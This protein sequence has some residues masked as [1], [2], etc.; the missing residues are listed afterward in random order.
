MFVAIMLFLVDASVTVGEVLAC[1][2]EDNDAH[3][4]YAIAVKK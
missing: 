3:D 4:K 2:R 1:E